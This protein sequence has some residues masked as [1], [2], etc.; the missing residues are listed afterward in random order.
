MYKVRCTQTH[1]CA[2]GREE[3]QRI[4]QVGPHFLHVSSNVPRSRHLG[5]AKSGACWAEVAR[6]ARSTIVPRHR[7]W[8]RPHGPLA[9][10][11]GA[12]ALE[13]LRQDHGRPAAALRILR[14]LATSCNRKAGGLRL[15][16]P[17]ILEPGIRDEI[18]ATGC[19]E[20][21]GKWQF[22]LLKMLTMV[23]ARNSHTIRQVETS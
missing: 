18:I 1:T 23:W 3:L 11:R 12:V 6:P 5:S 17:K 9:P 13:S 7:L 10:S 2:C 22:G 15:P 4:R 19:A 16:T 8:P 20:E 14:G 21:Y